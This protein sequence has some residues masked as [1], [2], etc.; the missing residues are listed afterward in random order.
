M[1]LL[2]ILFFAIPET[3]FEYV[4]Y[5]S[6]MEAAAFAI[7]SDSGYEVKF[8]K[9][10]EPG[11]APEKERPDEFFFQG[12]NRFFHLPLRMILFARKERPDVVFVHSFIFPVQLM[13]LRW[14]LPSSARI[15]IQH[16]AERPFRNKLKRWF[17]RKAYRY[18]DAFLFSSA[19]LADDFVDLRIIPS[20]QKVH[21][22]ME[23][24]CTFKMQDKQK[25][26][27]KLELA[28]GTIFIWVGRL[29]ENKDPLTVLK[30]LQQA[31]IAGLAF[32]FYMLYSSFEME[33][34]IK[35]FVQKHNLSDAVK[36][37]GTVA[38]HDLE[39]WFSAADY[40]I[41]ASHYEGSG[42]ALCEAMACGCIPVVTRIHSFTSMTDEGKV[43][44]LFAPSDVNGLSRIL[45]DLD[46]ARQE[47][48]SNKTMEKFQRDLSF[49]A[50]GQQ[51]LSIA[52]KLG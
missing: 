37:I 46:P 49:E 6:H 21:Q 48:D 9:L 34:E 45:L 1:K 44:H 31:K 8:L 20:R 10:H 24:S 42:I 52:R 2:N 33:A 27:E 4:K 19:Q 5:R 25:A 51:I 14:L 50:I 11:Y 43:G 7:F 41:A 29:N 35:D 13:V 30:A 32:T 16:H 3:E 23:S 28:Q 47:T 36:L 17:Q 38:H 40:F 18:A 26:R 12:R 39:T 22:V 15:I